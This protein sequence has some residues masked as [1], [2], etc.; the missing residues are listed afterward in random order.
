LHEETLALAD[1]LGQQFTLS[2]QDIRDQ[3]AH[4]FNETIS[5]QVSLIKYTREIGRSNRAAEDAWLKGDALGAFVERQR[6]LRLQ[7]LAEHAKK[8]EKDQAT[9]VRNRNRFKKREVEG[10]PAEYTNWVH[11]IFNRVGDPIRDPTDLAREIDAHDSKT[12]ADFIKDRSGEAWLP[13]GYEAFQT[14]YLQSIPIWEKLIDEPEWVK[15]N[16]TMTVGEFRATN[17]SIK[18][19]IKAGRDELRGI[20]EGKAFDRQER[21]NEMTKAFQ[22]TMIDKLPPVGDPTTWQQTKSFVNRMVVSLLQM[23]YIWGRLDQTPYGGIFY[24]HFTE[25]FA[26]AGNEY[27]L[28]IA[29]YGRKLNEIKKEAAKGV[30]LRKNTI[31]NDVLFEPRHGLPEEHARAIAPE[32]LNKGYLNRAQF[33]GVMLN[34]GN[35]SNLDKLAR[36]YHT[37]PEKIMEWV[38]KH[39]TQQDWDYVQKV[40]KL[41]DEIQGKDDII[42]REMSGVALERLPIGKVQT[43]FGEID[44]GYYP[45]IY[46][47]LRGGGGKGGKIDPDMPSGIRIL[48]DRGW[49]RKRTGYAGPV[50]LELGQIENQLT[51]R[52]RNIAFREVLEESQRF[53]RNA[54]F[55]SDMTRHL[56]PQYTKLLIPYLRDIAGVRG[57]IPEWQA[58]LERAMN[59][60]QQNT[61][62]TFVGFNPGTLVKHNVT[63]LVQSFKEVKDKRYLASAAYDLFMSPKL[64]E[65]HKFITEGEGNLGPSAEIKGRRPNWMEALGGETDAI[66]GQ[67]TTRSMVAH[68]LSWPIAFVDQMISKW[69]YYAKYNEMIDE[70]LPKMTIEEAHS[71]AQAIADQAVRRTHGSTAITSRPAA[72]RVPLLKPLTALYGFFNHIFNRMYEISWEARKHKDL[73]TGEATRADATHIASQLFFALIPAAI[74]EEVITPL[75]D[76][77][78]RSLLTRFGMALGFPIGSSV[79]IVREIVHGLFSGHDPSFGILQGSAKAIT[80]IGRQ[81]KNVSDADKY[82]DTL[83]AVH[84]LGGVAFGRSG[85]QI[86]RWNK[87][88]YNYF[89]GRDQPQTKE[90]WYRALRYGTSKERRH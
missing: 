22:A 80:D 88:A 18:A 69:L 32:L 82:G 85:Q 33:R 68:T 16:Q 54:Q 40:W 84:T 24:K 78:D 12:L 17:E 48:T 23:E 4:K 58:Y 62:L 74:I 75:F 44:G 53:F 70:F 63:A 36:G 6:T 79:P 29:D 65:N 5:G 39:A 3:A 83:Q 37:T 8:F 87:F 43:N 14:E 25:P 73:Q 89:T 7:A 35:T 90:E 61:V 49:E 38:N 71:K 26:K 41:F 57:P 13:E 27:R 47:Q 51:R 55:Q 30:D 72:M 81:L 31:P 46:D 34:V 76:K 64:M 52:L 28:L 67:Q 20:L 2:K 21:L 9:F 56:G 10:L 1:K 77:D 42:A 15:H 66:T 50:S 11:H 45:M 60:V 59:Y 86:G 19:L